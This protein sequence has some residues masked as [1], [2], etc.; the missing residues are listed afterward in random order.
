MWKA[1]W[2]K[3]WPGESAR[4][5]GCRADLAPIAPDTGKALLQA[6]ADG[7]LAAVRALIGAGVDLETR[8]A[9]GRTALMRAAHGGHTAVVQALWAAGADTEVRDARNW[10]ALMIAAHEGRLPSV[11]V[12]AHAGARRLSPCAGA[13][14]H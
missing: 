5:A 14:R 6:A 11:R 9:A 2:L 4:R 12:L 1:R 7:D 3:W 13:A 10:S 8:D